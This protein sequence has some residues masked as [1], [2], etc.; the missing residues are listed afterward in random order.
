M[1]PKEARPF[2]HGGRTGAVCEGVSSLPINNT[3]NTSA[4]AL[5]HP[6]PLFGRPTAA[7]IVASRSTVTRKGNY[8]AMLLERAEKA[9]ADLAAVHAAAQEL[10]EYYA[11]PKFQ[12]VDN[13]YAHVRTDVYPRVTAL[14]TL[15]FPNK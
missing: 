3:I 12:G 9:E 13:D 8:I 14:W 7:M 10:R 6:A 2:Y 15:S 11:S 4:R 5:P 1:S